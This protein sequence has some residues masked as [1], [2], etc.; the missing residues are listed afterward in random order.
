MDKKMTAMT[1]IITLQI[2][3]Y[4]RQNGVTLPWRIPEMALLQKSLCNGLVTN[5]LAFTGRLTSHVTSSFINL[6][7]SPVTGPVTSPV[8]GLAPT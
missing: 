5:P 1:T 3:P 2:T 7:T 8:N 4:R 6:V